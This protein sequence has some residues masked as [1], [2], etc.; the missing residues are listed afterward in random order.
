VKK[1]IIIVGISVIIL[2]GILIYIYYPRSTDF[3]CINCDGNIPSPPKD[4]C[5]SNV[6]KLI[7]I[8]NKTT[9]CTYL[10]SV[11]EVE[12]IRKYCNVPKGFV[13]NI[14]LMDGSVCG[15]RI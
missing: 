15:V 2:L 13:F 1:A 7:E 14:T 4:K 5:A 6:I 3:Y 12:E 10:N 11:K 9:N 8:G